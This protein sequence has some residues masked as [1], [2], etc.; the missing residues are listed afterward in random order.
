MSE[1]IVVIISLDEK[2]KPETIVEKIRKQSNDQNQVLLTDPADTVA[3]RYHIS[4]K[5][6][7]TDVLLFP[8][9]SPITDSLSSA[10]LNR[11]EGL[12]VYFDAHDR[13]FLERL[14]AFGAFVQQQDIDFGIL[15]CTTLPE[16]ASEGVTYGEAKQLCTVLDVIELEPAPED[17]EP[18]SDE[19]VGVDELI[20]AMHNHIWS[21]VQIHRGSRAAAALEALVDG[22]DAEPSSALSDDDATDETVEPNS[23]EEEERMEAAL[24]GFE[25]LLTEVRNMH[26]N[27]TSWSRNERLAYAQEL[28]EMFDNMV[29]EDD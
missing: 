1:P 17:D 3:Y 7:E 13:T 9:A 29:E 11:T 25:K 8:H 6:Y 15:L 28:A 21:N 12:L 22:T 4:T 19:A 20:Q 24:N 10:I 5:Y 23:N 14:P 2:V 27:A 16:N 18:P 26:S